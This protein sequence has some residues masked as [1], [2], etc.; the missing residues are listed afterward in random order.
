MTHP[1][2]SEE[3]PLRAVDVVVFSSSTSCLFG[4]ADADDDAEDAAPLPPFGRSQ[5]FTEYAW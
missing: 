3:V 2:Y 1:P 5:F 4:S